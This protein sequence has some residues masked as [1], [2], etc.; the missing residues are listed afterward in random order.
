MRMQEAI[1]K[2]QSTG[3]HFFDED[4]IEFWGTK[5]ESDLFD[6]RCFVTSEDDFYKTKRL[7]TVRQ[8]SEKYDATETIGE[9]QQ[10]QTKEEAVEAA[11]EIEF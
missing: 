3:K 8:F 11:K 7:F 4:T 5:L 2:Y 1:K 10:Y 6:N 9:F